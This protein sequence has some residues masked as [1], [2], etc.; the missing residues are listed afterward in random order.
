MHFG[1]TLKLLRVEA[2]L[3]LRAMAREVG[4]SSA[5]LSRVENERDPAPTPERLAAI[6]DA[7]ALPPDLL[8]ELAHQTA[9]A[10]ADY[11][12]EVPAA[13]AF[14]LEVARRRL[15]TAQL[16]RLRDL[17]HRELNGDRPATDR[18]SLA[19]IVGP[20]IAVRL[21]CADLDGVV[22]AACAQLGRDSDD[23]DELARR[24]HERERLAPTALGNGVAVPH[25]IVGGEATA[26]ALMTLA[27]P[28]A[29]PSPDGRDIEVAVVLVSG[30][31]G[32][33]HLEVLAQI[34]RLASRDVAGELCAARTAAEIRSI[35]ERGEG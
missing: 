12:E 29:Y 14:F 31:P 15:D 20:R 9:P 35:I 24:I 8:I 4:V 27:E 2:G 13:S 34:A 32:R 16:A 23:A 18:A 5:Y 33:P 17:M 30:A 1:S 3:T 22:V 10:I 26:A 21:R 7:L 19:A 28:I 25:A 6:A 11:L